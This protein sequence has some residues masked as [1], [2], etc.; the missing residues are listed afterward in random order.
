MKHKRYVCIDQNILYCIPASRYV[1]NSI[2]EYEEYRFSISQYWTII[3]VFNIIS[4]ISRTHSTVVFTQSQLSGNITLLRTKNE[5]RDTDT[6]D[7]I[8]SI[9][10]NSVHF[11]KSV[12]EIIRKII[13]I[14]KCRLLDWLIVERQIS[15]KDLLK[16]SCKHQSHTPS[17]I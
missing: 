5:S 10:Q 11:N 14:K 1:I 8:T 4:N 12:S 6:L 3:F 13:Y 15:W 17:M 9:S 7:S 2:H 16:I